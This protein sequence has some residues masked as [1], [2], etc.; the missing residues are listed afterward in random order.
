MLPGM[1]HAHLIAFTA[2]FGLSAGA[3]LADTTVI[4]NGLAAECSSAARSVASNA[5]SRVEAM[6]AI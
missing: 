5:P 6:R 1:R 2:A 3:A 4:G